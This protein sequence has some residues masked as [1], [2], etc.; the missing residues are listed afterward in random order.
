MKR[1]INKIFMGVMLAGTTVLASCSSDY[2]EVGPTE[3]TSKELALG[4]TSNLYKVLNGIAKEMSTQQ[5]YY[6]QGFA[7][8]NAIMRLYENLPSQN[9]NYN[10]YA[11]GWAPLHNQTFHER[12]TTIYNNYAWFYY[13]QLIASANAVICNVDKAEGSEADKQFVK[14]SALTYRAYA[15]QKLV[16]YYCYRWQDSNNGT[17]NGVVLRLDESTGDLPLSTLGD[18]YAQIY[19]DLDDA[20]SLF[21]KSGLNRPSGRVW[22]ANEDVAH[23]V[24]ARAAL[25][26]QDY[27]KAL[28]EAQL[29]RKNHPLMSQTDYQA[30]F[31][32]PNNEW[33]MGS[34]GDASENNWY[35][36][37]GVQGACNG[38]YSNSVG[39]GAGSINHELIQR[40]PNNDVRKQI[41]ITEDKIPYFV[42]IKKALADSL[43]S[44]K[45]K[46]GAD[47]AKFAKDSLDQVKAYKTN[48]AN[49]V[50]QTYG[51]LGFDIDEVWN[52][53]DSV[54]KAHTPQGMDAAYQCG[55]I[56][57][58]GQLKFWVTSQPGV[59][60][61]PFIR[62]AEMY[63]IEAEANYF[64]GNE[65][66]AQ[67]VLTELNQ[68]RNADYTCTKTGQ[69][70]F[71]E[72]KDYRALELWGEGFEWS[73][74]KRWNIS[75]VRHSFAEGGNA[76]PA[77]AK[78]IAPDFGNRWTW[79][80]PQAETDYNA[81]LKNA[82]ASKKD[83]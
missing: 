71:E 5:Y 8:E 20:I 10:Y 11:S 3:S 83:M 39:T 9:F 4:N 36:S 48:Y 72:I 25:T 6:G 17:S 55:Y 33:I 19:K 81:L 12:K 74:Y 77:V 52:Q 56:Y 73:D 46:D 62:S 24:Y 70:L 53:A 69:D 2:L 67:K 47:A 22:L 59:S 78:T 41:F 64:L 58:D 27:Q 29:A 30:G 42:D 49:G 79:V 16:N 21:E 54:V 37:F 43:A 63:L 50:D 13:Y 28:T 18:T 15:Y 57:L 45:E 26:K 60:Y 1:Y 40:I 82:D 65:T 66:E 35:W 31:C 44:Y 61:V 14:A 51:L 34:Y 23:S 32:A 38:Y 80:I 68:A 7:G 76:H 75:V